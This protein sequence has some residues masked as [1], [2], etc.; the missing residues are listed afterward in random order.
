MV[1][2]PTAYNYDW[3]A[4]VEEQQES[5]MNMKKFCKEKSLPYQSFKNHKY[6]LESQVC[7]KEGFLP[8]KAGTSKE[9]QFS[10]N[11]N[12]IRFDASLDDESVSRILKAL[13]S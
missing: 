13:T 11:G 8:V 7:S 5:G 6:A 9:V 4:L 3:R 2:V 10:L 1:I 12:I